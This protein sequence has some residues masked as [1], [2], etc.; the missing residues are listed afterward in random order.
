MRGALTHFVI[1]IANYRLSL[2]GVC[3]SCRAQT[4]ITIS[5]SH[6]H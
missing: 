1:R 5:E 3:G 4:D 6:L 2:K